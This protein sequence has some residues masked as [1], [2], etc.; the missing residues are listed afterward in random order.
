MTSKMPP[1][2]RSTRLYPEEIQ[3]NRPTIEETRRSLPA[4]RPV[5]ALVMRTPTSSTI[6]PPPPES[7]LPQSMAELEKLISK[8][9]TIGMAIARSLNNRRQLVEMNRLGNRH[10]ST[11]HTHPEEPKRTCSYKDF[12]NCKPRNY[13]GN[14]GI[15]GL[16][17]WIENVEAVF[18]IYY[19]SEGSKVHFSAC[20][21]INGALTWWTDRV[22]TFGISVA[23]SILW[24]IMKALLIKEYCPRDEVQSLEHEL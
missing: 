4:T 17:H 11:R 21:F 23:N 8:R 9:I 20:I 24:E 3:T 19:C 7:R 13:Y 2:R 18:D 5:V 6:M 12:I 10:G 16:S 15:V 1:R 22:M 14:E